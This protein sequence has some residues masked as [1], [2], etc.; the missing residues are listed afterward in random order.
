MRAL[1]KS[2][3]ENEEMAREMGLL[4]CCKAKMRWRELRVANRKCATCRTK[5]PNHYAT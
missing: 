5:H 1:E 4:I 2:V 3:L